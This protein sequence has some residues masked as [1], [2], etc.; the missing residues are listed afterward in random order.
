[1]RNSSAINNNPSV[2]FILHNELWIFDLKEKH[3]EFKRTNFNSGKGGFSKII[4]LGGELV[5][6]LN[7]YFDNGLIL[8]DLEVNKAYKPSTNNP[9]PLKRIGFDVAFLNRTNFLL[10]GGFFLN[11]NKTT[12]P[13]QEDNLI[14]ILFNFTTFQPS[15][16][17]SSSIN[18]S[19]TTK[20]IL[21]S[22]STVDSVSSTIIYSNTT[23]KV[24]SMTTP[25]I[26]SISSSY[27]E[28]LTISGVF[29]NFNNSEVVDMKSTLLI[30]L[31]PTFI[32]FAVFAKLWVVRKNMRKGRSQNAISDIINGNTQGVPISKNSNDKSKV[33]FGQGMNQGSS[34]VAFQDE[35]VGNAEK[36]LS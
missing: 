29:N 35:N 16:L 3:P 14:E 26:D 34:P 27:T 18:F 12:V 25:M 6:I 22:P 20:T 7:S 19:T 31:I 32:I 28:S 4:T 11:D 15:S 5:G 23:S 10:I 9:I 17:I 30:V 2:Q 24:D 21:E 33:N 8:L 1:M 36:D 13:N